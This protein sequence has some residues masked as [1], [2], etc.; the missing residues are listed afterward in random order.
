MLHNVPHLLR[1]PIPP[2][3]TIWYGDAF[4]IQHFEPHNSL[5]IHQEEML[6]S[7]PHSLCNFTTTHPMMA[8]AMPL[9]IFYCRQKYMH[10]KKIRPP[11]PFSSQLLHLHRLAAPPINLTLFNNALSPHGISWF[12]ETIRPVNGR[13]IDVAF[14]LSI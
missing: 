13:L 6:P 2:K 11:P 14:L 9:A 4:L 5:K 3:T 7:A 10:A 8:T 12:S 1:T